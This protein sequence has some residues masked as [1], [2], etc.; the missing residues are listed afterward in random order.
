MPLF[1]VCRHGVESREEGSGSEGKERR[2]INMMLRPVNK[3]QENS[4]HTHTAFT[5]Y[6]R[7]FFPL[8]IKLNFAYCSFK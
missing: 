2:C 6:W 7:K 8:S 5:L 4:A 3:E 1:V